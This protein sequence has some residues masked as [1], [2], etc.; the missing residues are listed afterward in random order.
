MKTAKLG[1]ALSICLLLMASVCSASQE[2]EVKAL[3]DN[4]ITFVQDKGQDYS[5]KVFSALNGPFVKGPLYVAVGDFGGQILAH[6][7]KK[8][9]GQS[10]W[11]T[12][13][14]KGKLFVQE[15]VGVAKGD[16]TGWVEY[17]VA[18]PPYKRRSVEAFIRKTGPRFRSLDCRRIL[19]G[20]VS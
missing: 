19:S 11:E 12:K 14:I 18:P 3:V 8:L 20:I 9:L 7:N 6:P 5:M 17:L 4:A 15:I 13:D 16:G 10:L 2:E 1:L